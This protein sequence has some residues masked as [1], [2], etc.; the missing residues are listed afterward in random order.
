MTLVDQ[1]LLGA[2]ARL[3]S[4]GMSHFDAHFTNVLTDGHQIYLSDFGLATARQFQL[5]SPEMNFVQLTV[6]HDLAY[7]AAAL[8]NTIAATRIWFADPRE[9][10]D[11]VRRCAGSGQATALAGVLADTV[12]RYAPVATV[13][14]DFYWQL[15]NGNVAAPYPAD[16]ISTRSEVP[17][18]PC[19]SRLHRS[20]RSSRD[21]AT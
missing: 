6:D 17:A 12:V 19:N 16:A 3:R 20:R 2:V 8:V 9:R 21:G 15:H 14:N 7:C 1:Q 18:F 4:A 11:Y 13:V 5:S 10:N